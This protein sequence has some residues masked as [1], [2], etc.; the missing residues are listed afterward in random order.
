[1]TEQDP[2]LQRRWLAV[3]IEVLA[4]RPD[5]EGVRVV[6]DSDIIAATGYDERSV[7]LVWQ[8]MRRSGM[9][10]VSRSSGGLRRVVPLAHPLWVA[11]EAFAGG[12]S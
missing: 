6:R 8:E 7:R 11:A 10:K 1:M 4:A 9:A 2:Y 5:A 12:E 3:A